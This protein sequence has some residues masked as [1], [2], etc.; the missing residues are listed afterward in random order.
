M[1]DILAKMD[2]LRTYYNKQ[3]GLVEA[4]KKSGAGQDDVYVPKWPWFKPLSFPGDHLKTNPTKSNIRVPTDDNNSG[5]SSE[6]SSS[7]GLI[8]SSRSE[9]KSR[10]L[11]LSQ[12]DQLITTALIVTVSGLD[13]QCPT[14]YMALLL[15][16]LCSHCGLPV[17]ADN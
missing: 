16:S 17:S 4:R 10:A 9:P 2:S 8:Y 7:D 3:R 5:T 13:S 6:N 1:K 12:E 11:K 14:M 15:E